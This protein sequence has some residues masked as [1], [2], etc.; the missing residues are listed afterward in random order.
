MMGM[1]GVKR[2]CWVE[3]FNSIRG[4]KKARLQGGRRYGGKGIS[5]YGINFHIGAPEMMGTE[6]ESIPLT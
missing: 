5:G 1:T 3:K 2:E 6:Y 4:R